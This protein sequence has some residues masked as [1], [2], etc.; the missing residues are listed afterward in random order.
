[1]IGYLKGRISHKTPAFIY[2]ECSGVGYHVNISLSTYGRLEGLKEA[3]IFTHMQVREDDISLYGFFEEEERHLF[4]HLI[5]VSGIGC[6]TARVILSYM[7]T[8]ELKKA[9]IHEDE[10]AL[11]KVKGIGPKT[12]KRIILDL[13]DKMMK[14]SGAETIASSHKAD[15]TYREEAL[16]ALIA[17]GFPK[18][19]MEKQLNAI[20]A[21]QPQPE[22]VEEL[23]KNVLKQLN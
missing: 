16:S 10:F 21:K 12:A 11:G 7:N 13:K 9:I 14:T 17:L 20:L 22:S 8:D 6:N 4:V 15:H 1:M 19:G 5:S 3:T 2:L 23:I 18:A